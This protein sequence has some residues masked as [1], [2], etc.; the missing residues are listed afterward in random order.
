MAVHDFRDDAY[1][2]KAVQEARRDEGIGHWG[3][4][5]GGGAGEG[6]KCKRIGGSVGNAE[7]R[8]GSVPTRGSCAGVVGD[9]VLRHVGRIGRC[10]R[11][12]VD[13]YRISFA[14]SLSHC[15]EGCTNRGVAS[16]SLQRIVYKKA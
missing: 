5:Y 3:E 7:S 15:N 4:G 1:E 13:M 11:K 8:E 6:R 12:Q 2:S 16:G 9:L 14:R 10:H